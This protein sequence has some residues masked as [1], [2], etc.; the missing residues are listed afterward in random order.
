MAKYSPAL[1]VINDTL[2]SLWLSFF[3]SINS[4]SSPGL[5]QSD[6]D[7]KLGTGPFGISLTSGLFN[8]STTELEFPVDDIFEGNEFSA[9]GWFYVNSSMVDGRGMIYGSQA[10]SPFRKWG[11]FPRLSASGNAI[12]IV[13][14]NS[15]SRT[16]QFASP[17][18]LGEWH[19]LFF[20]IGSGRL[21]IYYDGVNVDGIN[22]SGTIT[23]PSNGLAIGFDQVFTR[24]FDGMMAH[25]GVWPFAFSDTEVDELYNYIL[26]N[27]GSSKG[28]VFQKSG[29][30][31][32]IRSRIPPL[33]RR[34]TRSSHSRNSF[35]HV[36]S[37]YKNL[38]S[39]EKSAFDTNSPLFP[40]VDSIG[41]SYNLSG[42][43]LFSSQNIGLATENEPL[44]FTSA[45]P[46]SPPSLISVTIEAFASISEF[47]M[48]FGLGSIPSDWIFRYFMTAMLSPGEIASNQNPF[49][50]LASKFET[51]NPDINLYDAWIAHF[52][53][54][55]SLVGNRVVFRLDNLHIPSG[56]V[57]TRFLSNAIMS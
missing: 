25:L 37:N 42:T 26:I 50:L 7:L 4:Y 12:C 55:L 28:N 49:V 46:V 47:N 38:S 43:N 5:I 45:I 51:D 17:N 34:N 23:T 19:H 3:R 27:R 22:I 14:T 35:T 40:R 48:L 2:P 6:I 52:G 20:T 11:I 39:G 33:K 8:G 41:R 53:N 54:N 56:Q 57:I 36:R 29:K 21:E 10:S 18:P 32:S 30:S 15:Q 31:F 24:Y 44:N 9:G 1:P 16:L 13:H